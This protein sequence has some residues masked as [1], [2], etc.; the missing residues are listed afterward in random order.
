MI[1]PIIF[2]AEIYIPAEELAI[3]VSYSIADPVT[4]KQEKEALEKLPHVQPCRR[5]AIITYDE[6]GILADEQDAI[7]VIPCW[8][9]LL[10]SSR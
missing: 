8:K 5:R 6:E 7:E 1:I 3:L 4:G 2:R 9:R 10:E